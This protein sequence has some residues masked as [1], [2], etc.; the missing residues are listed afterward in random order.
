MN[1]RVATGQSRCSRPLP[2]RTFQRRLPVQELCAAQPM[3]LLTL[4][5]AFMDNTELPP[6]ARHENHARN[7]PSCRPDNDRFKVDHYVSSRPGKSSGTTNPTEAS[8]HSSDMLLTN[9]SG[10]LYCPIHLLRVVSM[11]SICILNPNAPLANPEPP[12][13]RTEILIDPRL[14]ENYTAVI[15]SRRI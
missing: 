15:K 13:Q 7:S 1:Q 4:L 2:T 3:T 11:T 12:K 6:R 9:V 10:S 5:E 8:V 14:L